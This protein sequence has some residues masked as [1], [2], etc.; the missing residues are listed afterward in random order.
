ML[1][2]CELSFHRQ[3][4]Y[5]VQL[6]RALPLREACIGNASIGLGCRQ[7]KKTENGGVFFSLRR[8]SREGRGGSQSVKERKGQE[9]NAR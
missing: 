8:L 7:I 4:R 5:C 9:E 6:P 3:T 1:S 2:V